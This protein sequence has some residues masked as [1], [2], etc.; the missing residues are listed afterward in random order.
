MKKYLVPVLLFAIGWTVWAE[1][2]VDE[3]AGATI[4]R[5]TSYAFGMMIGSNLKELNVSFNYTAFLKGMREILEDKT[6]NLTIDEAVAKVE[7]AYQEAMAKK[8][9][10]GKAK[11]TAFFEENA[12]KPG[13]QTT[14]SG[15]QYEVI[16]QGTGDKPALSD[17]VTVHYR[18]TF[19]DGTVFDS[20]YDREEPTEFPLY[21]V[22]PGWS[23]G[24]QLMNVGS[25]YRLFIPSDLA[26]G[27]QGGGS[28]IPPYSTLIFE[29]ELLSI[30][31]S[32]ETQPEDF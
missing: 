20:S 31:K 14:E 27:A 29:V 19:I 16:T 23:E 3:D 30:A 5:D 8:S 2:K 17:T 22:I 10:E 1:G 13:I 6:T 28:V 25:K 4:D 9:E 26:Y 15:L 11:E 12:K 32:E 21:A 24:V 7:A 18:G